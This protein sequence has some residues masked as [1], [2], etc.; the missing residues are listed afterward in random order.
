M[1]T[2]MR[3]DDSGK[4][5]WV[6]DGTPANTDDP[7]FDV[8]P[9]DPPILDEVDTYKAAGWSVVSDDTEQGPDGDTADGGLPN[10][11]DPKDDWVAAAE[12][13][14]IDPT[15]KTKAELIDELS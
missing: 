5:R 8:A 2:K 3:H 4:I 13:A 12:A 15:G 6:Q 14:G 11:S 7:A 10:Q 1:P 9:E